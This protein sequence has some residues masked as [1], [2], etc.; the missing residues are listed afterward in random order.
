MKIFQPAGRKFTNERLFSPVIRR[1]DA[2]SCVCMLVNL[3]NVA[4]ISTS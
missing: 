1:Y 2:C 3:D 4:A